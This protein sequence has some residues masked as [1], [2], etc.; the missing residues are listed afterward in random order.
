VSTSISPSTTITL[1]KVST[2]KYKLRLPSAPA[3]KPFTQQTTG[4]RPRKHPTQ[5][6]QLTLRP[7]RLIDANL[8]PKC[9]IHE[10]WGNS[11]QDIDPT[12][13]FRLIFQ[14]PNG[15]KLS[16]AKDEFLLGA[17]TCHSLGAAAIFLAETNTN[18]NQPYQLHK[19]TSAF[20][21]I[22]SKY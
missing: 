6:R 12:D 16:T 5:P 2:T 11:L 21:D 22:W 8:N 9:P 1:P 18:W 15:L 10:V 7:L 14:N 4:S 3:V 20:R 17:K 19:L 13:T